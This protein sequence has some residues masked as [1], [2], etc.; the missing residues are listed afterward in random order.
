M[1][2][3]N[4]LEKLQDAYR[5]K[6]RYFQI[7]LRCV[8]CTISFTKSP[9]LYIDCQRHKHAGNHPPLFARVAI[10]GSKQG[11]EPQVRKFSLC[12]WKVSPPLLLQ[13]GPSRYSEASGRKRTDESSRVIDSIEDS[14]SFKRRYSPPL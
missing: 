9:K 10:F 7:A 1:L 11:K 5:P 6:S 8:K 13:P 2:F 4:A 3:D 12:S 14:V